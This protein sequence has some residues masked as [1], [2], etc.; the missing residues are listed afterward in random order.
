MFVFLGGGCLCVLSWS[1]KVTIGAQSGYIV[2]SQLKWLL[3]LKGLNFT[4]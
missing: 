1:T 4:C 3:G 2:H